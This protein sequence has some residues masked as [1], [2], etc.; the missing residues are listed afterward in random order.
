MIFADGASSMNKD[1]GY[2]GIIMVKDT[3]EVIEFGGESLGT[4]NN[5]MELAAAIHGLALLRKL[6][7]E[8]NLPYFGRSKVVSD[9]QYVVFG[10]REWVKGW[11]ANGWMTNGE[12][13]VKN[14]D[15]W[16]KLINIANL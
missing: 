3:R 14:V 15:L 10:I 16:K 12:Q 6:C 11:E 7:K 13:P 2:G 5:Q 4:T 1:G 8:R 9:S